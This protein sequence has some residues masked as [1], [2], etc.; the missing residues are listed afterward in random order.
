MSKEDMDNFIALLRR[1]RPRR[2]KAYAQSAAMFALYCRENG[3]DDIRFDSI[4]TSAEVL[5]P[6]NRTLIE[7]T[8]RG[9]IFNRYGCRE[10]SVIASECEYHTGLHVNADALIVEIDPIA[11]G[12]PG[13]G[14][15]LITDL[16]NRSMPLI[17]Y[18]IG[19]IAR[20]AETRQ[21]ACGRSL[22]RLANIEGRITDFLHLPDG[23]MVSGP[24]LT[25]VIAQLSEIR[26]A[27]FVQTSVKD[28][29]L[30][31][32]PREGYGP[33][34]V[35]ELQRRL[36]PYLRGQVRLTIRAVDRILSEKS[37][38]YRFVKKEFEEPE[39][40]AALPQPG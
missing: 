13:S 35:E 20:W 6:E 21:C 1:Y 25:L 38:K 7:E 23:K 30:D 32:V 19:D 9:K 37:G 33:H 31:I 5:L 10:L 22:P 12:Q 34:T 3:V 16:Y 28:V 26:Q 2:L 36:Y 15:V 14:R 18:E 39:L 11:D 29:R 8:F 24:S 27:Q 17:R 40:R 4:I